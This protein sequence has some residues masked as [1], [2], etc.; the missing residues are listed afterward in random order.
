MK[1]RYLS[2]VLGSLVV[3]TPAFAA[4][5][6]PITG[7]VGMASDYSWRG[8]SQT[9]RKPAT[10]G[11]F[12]F[13]ADSGVYLGI[14]GSNVNFNDEAAAVGAGANSYQRAQMEG[15]LYGGFKFKAGAVEMDLGALHYNY[16]GAEKSLA[17]NFT[18]FYVGATYDVLSVKYSYSPDFQTDIPDVASESASYLEL[19]ANVPLPMGLTLA[20]HAGNSSGAFFDQA[21][22]AGWLIKSY[23][24]YKVGFTKEVSGVTLG[25]HYVDTSLSGKYEVKNGAFANNGRVVFSLYKS[26]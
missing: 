11:G 19:N 6:S 21:E 1:Q 24:D 13:A 7:N 17:Y 9:A 2:A 18:E 12:D 3:A 5:K 8:I 22:K 14:W 4:D 23:T 20:L 26:L 25:L 15:D 10:Q 16:P